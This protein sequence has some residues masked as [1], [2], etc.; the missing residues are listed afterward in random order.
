M[1]LAGLNAARYWLS[2]ALAAA[3]LS[4][5]LPSLAADFQFDDY[6]VIV[7][8]TRVQS[9]TAWL[10]SMPGMR[11]LLKLSY[12]L[13]HEFGH[14]PRG[15]RLVNIL[16]HGANACLVLRLFERASLRHGLAPAAALGVAAATALLF[17]FHPVQTEAVTYISGR[18]S[19]LSALACLAALSAWLRA[20]ENPSSG[21]GMRWWAALFF[22]FA[23]AVK[24]SSL[25]LPV[26]LLCWWLAQPNPPAA[27]VAWRASTPML[28]LCLAGT[29]VLFALP[30][31]R[32][33]VLDALSRR[34]LWQN[35]LLQAEAIPY[36]AGQLLALGSMNPDPDLPM[37]SGLTPSIAL[38]L[39]LLLLLVGGAVAFRRRYPAFAFA[40]L[41]FFAWLLPTH[42]LLPREDPVNDRQ[43]Y[44]AMAGPVW[45]VIFS[46]WYII[47]R[48]RTRVSA[49]CSIS[50]TVA[51][52]LV[53]AIVAAVLAAATYTH[54][55]A[56]ATETSFWEDVAAKSPHKPRVL[57]NLGYAYALAC[58]DGEAA[59][60]FERVIALDPGNTLAQVNLDLLRKGLLRGRQAVP[61]PPSGV[62]PPP[63]SGSDARHQRG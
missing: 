61:C 20:V 46:S 47:D 17:A 58:R 18:S 37:P 60:M 12:A 9:F 63:E 7:R 19:S 32:Q 62:G 55:R 43:L 49:C 23:L 30:A 50:S 21:Q 31:F 3:T 53:L 10:V 13:G 38:R 16:V 45:F 40:T 41:W 54:N 24:E 14:G 15:F 6:L 11:P 39:A 52:M 33:L 25:V 36:L 44:L 51:A 42:S 34:S 29:A 59:T 22:V 35:L 27:R 56:Y 4:L 26:I 5:Y 8:D 57:N 1:N 28:A 2:L 48:W